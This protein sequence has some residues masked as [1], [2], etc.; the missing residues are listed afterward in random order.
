MLDKIDSTQQ[1]Y[2]EMT[3]SKIP[4][5]IF[6]G[7]SNESKSRGASIVSYSFPFGE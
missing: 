6:F 3:V 5:N 4:I 7:Q 1:E 2:G